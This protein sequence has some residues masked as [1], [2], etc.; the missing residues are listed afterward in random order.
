[1]RFQYYSCFQVSTEGLGTYSPLI[2]RDYYTLASDYVQ[3]FP[4]I[5][6]T[7]S[8]NIHLAPKADYVNKSKNCETF[9]ENSN[10]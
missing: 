10:H 7:N 8:S 4:K 5:V 3:L 9:K 2:R 6:T 1:M